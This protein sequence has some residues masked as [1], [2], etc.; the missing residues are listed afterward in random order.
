[1]I[2]QKKTIIGNDYQKKTIIG[3]DYQ[4]K[5]NNNNNNNNNKQQQQQQ[6]QHHHHHHYYATTNLSALIKL[7]YFFFFGLGMAKKGQKTQQKMGKTTFQIYFFFD[8]KKFL[9]KSEGFLKRFVWFN[10]SRKLSVW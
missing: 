7:P 10:N 4:K 6:Q 2:I 9:E 5:N 8:T 3:N 1:M